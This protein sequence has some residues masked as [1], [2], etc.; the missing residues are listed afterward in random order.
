M[1][2]TLR[3]GPHLRQW[4][5]ATVL[6]LV[7]LQVAAAGSAAAPTPQPSDLSQAFDSLERAVTETQV[8]FADDPSR[9][10]RYRLIADARSVQP[11]HQRRL[12]SFS[13]ESVGRNS[14]RRQADWIE[15]PWNPTANL[16]ER[17]QGSLSAL[18]VA[19]VD[20]RPE[21]QDLYSQSIRHNA[22]LVTMAARNEDA[23]EAQLILASVEQDLRRKLLSRRTTTDGPRLV[24]WISVTVRTRRRGREIDGFLIRL[25]PV[26]WMASSYFRSLDT[27]TSPAQGTAPPGIYDVIVLRNGIE[28]AR[29]RG[30]DIGIG[31]ATDIDVQVP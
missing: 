11:E 16:L 25:N 1:I 4:Q 8:L 26:R 15:I 14:V 31:G 30:R 20:I 5:I 19:S 27:E 22:D 7:G 23:G 10:L 12:A 13:R 9:S 21:E 17:I 3:F 6:F 28:V 18:R 29:D 24:G 2:A